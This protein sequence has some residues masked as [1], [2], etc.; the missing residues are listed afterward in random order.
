MSPLNR[1]SVPE[2]E[3]QVDAKQFLC[4]I[5][6]LVI[7]TKNQQDSA[8]L[9]AKNRYSWGITIGKA[10]LVIRNNVG[11][12]SVYLPQSSAIRFSTLESL[13]TYRDTFPLHT[14][15]PKPPQN[16]IAPFVS[17]L[18]IQH[19]YHSVLVVRD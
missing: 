5:P 12:R 17:F 9:W 6:V 3:I 7:T 18:G 1:N 8:V 11:V 14:I 10:V 15:N 19:I 4:R 16:G 13:C 2:L